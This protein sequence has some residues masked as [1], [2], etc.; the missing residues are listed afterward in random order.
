M[1]S[2]I[3]LRQSDL[4]NIPF[5]VQAQLAE[6]PVEAQQD[7]I[8]EYQRRKKDLPVAYITHMVGL[9]EGYLDNW[10]LQIFFWLSWAVFI[11]PLWWFINLFRMPGKVE[12]FNK[13]LATK[14]LKY[15]HF[16]YK[17]SGK[18]TIASLGKGKMFEHPTAYLKQGKNIV[19]PRAWRYADAQSISIEHLTV[20][21]MLDHR[22]EMWEV[23][24][25]TQ[26]DWEDD[27][28]E[29]AFKLNQMGESTSFWLFVWRE[30]SQ[31]LGVKAQPV[32]IY[33]L[34]EGLELEIMERKRP[35]NVLNYQGRAY[36]REFS[37]TGLAFN[38]EQKDPAPYEIITWTY[39]DQE[40][41][42]II[43]IE[44]QGSSGFRAFAG[45]IVSSGEFSDIAINRK[46]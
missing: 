26:F 2:S 20:G 13:N 4:E 40:R 46:K 35:F 9:S 16:K 25:E 8:R 7:F 30:Y 31:V 19:R 27:T 10:T 11:G 24:S 15:I 23:V 29:K 38:L 34:N 43:R 12:R 28:S 41:K 39:Y 3:I 42:N 21:S 18:S 45:Q 5:A 22:T 37:K 1:S 44:R 17:I 6:L 33:A 14:A 36:Y 32:N